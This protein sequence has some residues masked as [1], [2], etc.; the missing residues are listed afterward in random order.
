MLS[1]AEIPKSP[2]NAGNKP[3]KHPAQAPLKIPP[4]IPIAARPEAPPD[5]CLMSWNLL[6]VRI[7]TKA[8]RKGTIRKLKRRYG[9][10]NPLYKSGRVL[11]VI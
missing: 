1:V 2:M 9:I 3:T 6:M 10:R 5:I 4:N 11:N 7:T 8:I